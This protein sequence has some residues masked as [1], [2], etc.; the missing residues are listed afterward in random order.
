MAGLIRENFGTRDADDFLLQ[1]ERLY[2]GFPETITQDFYPVLHAFAD[3][4]TKE[5]GRMIG[6]ETALTPQIETFINEY[7]DIYAARHCGSSLGQLRKLVNETD[8]DILEDVLLQRIGE[9]RETRPGKIA[10]D[11][12]IRVANAV[13]RE[14]WKQQGIT[15]L[16][17]V[18][19]GSKICPFCKQLNGKVVGIE[20]PFLEKGDVL[21][22]HNKGH[23]MSIK[24]KK[25][26]PPIH[27]GC[28]CAILPLIE[29]REIFNKANPE[30]FIKQRDKLPENLMA[31]VTPYSVEAYKRKNIELFLADSGLSGFGLTP[32]KELVSVFSLP[33]ANQGRAAV[34]KAVEKGAKNL[35]CFDTKLVEFYGEFGF[36]EVKRFQWEKEYAPKNWDY[37]KF[38][39]PDL[40]IM[41]L[42]EKR[43]MGAGDYKRD[44][45]LIP[46]K[47]GEENKGS[48][49]FQDLADEFISVVFGESTLERLKRA[50]TEE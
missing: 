32:D 42:K 26:H 19:Q 11:E 30:D 4:V 24:G 21:K 47:P 25:S 12:A 27:K 33:G 48:Q 44:P 45:N 13:A 10:D 7:I 16:K 40:V 3:L 15:K 31:F 37:K 9:W 29:T 34:K 1:L 43:S 23:W 49:A 17:W 8:A 46:V 18:T 36:K 41:S 28:R 39:T 38:K 22:G 6:G 35:D 2:G 5:S 20:S 14:N 50:E